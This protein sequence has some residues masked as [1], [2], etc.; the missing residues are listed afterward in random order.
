MDTWVWIVIAAVALLAILAIVWLAMQRRRTEM[1]REQFGP[2]YDRTIERA[3]DRRS[4]ES[5]LAERRAHREALDIRPLDP[6]TRARYAAQ[7]QEVQGR[8][9]DQPAIAVAQADELVTVVMRDRG[10]PT[11]D[12]ERRAADVS[13][14]HP[15]LVESYRA[16]NAISSRVGSNRASTED[17]RRA[18]V[19]YR[20]LFAELLSE[21]DD[22]AVRQAR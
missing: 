22:E 2:E 9:V 10:Y 7:W 3:D 19:H 11:D 5:E 1:L 21:T 18:L 4:A 8:F 6:A 17:L 16:A 15:N 14:D 12:F 13:V 20:A